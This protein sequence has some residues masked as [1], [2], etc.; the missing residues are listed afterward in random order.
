MDKTDAD[1]RACGADA[2]QNGFHERGQT[3][4]VSLWEGRLDITCQ[5]DYLGVGPVD[6]QFGL[7]MDSMFQAFVCCNRSAKDAGGWWAGIQ[8]PGLEFLH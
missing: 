8:Q 7:S 6:A 5:R 3:P 1:A 4:G 2:G